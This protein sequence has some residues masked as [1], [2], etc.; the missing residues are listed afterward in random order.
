M[1]P[2]KNRLSDRTSLLAVKSRGK[3][4]SGRNLSAVV[5]KK[6]PEDHPRFGIIVSTKISKLATQRNRIKRLIR[7]AIYKNLS[8]IHSGYDILILTKHSI[9]SRTEE[10]IE[11]DLIRV[12]GGAK[13]LK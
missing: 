9:I 4:F 12:L 6:S 2:R 3:L 1:L 8:K 7:S 10:E 5:L 11:S 13:I